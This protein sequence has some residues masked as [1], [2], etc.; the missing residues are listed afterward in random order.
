MRES[1]EIVIGEFDGRLENATKLPLPEARRAL[2]KFPGIA[3]PG[4][5]KILVLTRAHKVLALDSNGLRVLVRLGYGADDKNYTKMYKSAVAAAEAELA[6]D[7]DALIDAHLLLRHHGQEL[8]KTSTPRC[9]ACP[10]KKDCPTGK[11]R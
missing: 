11:W 9:T 1:A 4:A 2:Q 7:F 10:L 3:Q 5:D 8:C 6:H